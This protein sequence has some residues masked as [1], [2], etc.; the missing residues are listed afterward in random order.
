MST[1]LQE[2]L[3]VQISLLSDLPLDTPDVV[4]ISGH[5]SACASVDYTE[6]VDLDGQP[7]A[8]RKSGDN[9]LT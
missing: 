9:S 8:S 1:S 6:D 5:L 7:V 2:K 4:R 3:T